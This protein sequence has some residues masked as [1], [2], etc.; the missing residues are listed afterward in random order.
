MTRQGKSAHLLAYDHGYS[1]SGMISESIFKKTLHN[2]SNVMKTHFESLLNSSPLILFTDNLRCHCTLGVL[3]LAEKLLQ[4]H[5]DMFAPNSSHFLAP[6]DNK[7]F[8]IFKSELEMRY[9]ELLEASSMIGKK[10]KAPLC[11]VVAESFNKAFAPPVV[12]ESYANVGVWPFRPDII[13]E[14]ARKKT[15]HKNLKKVKASDSLK[16]EVVKATVTLHENAVKKLQKSASAFE[17]IPVLTPS[18]RTPRQHTAVANFEE[19]KGRFEDLLA[20]ERRRAQEKGSQQKVQVNRR[21]VSVESEVERSSENRVVAVDTEQQKEREEENEEQ[22]S[23]MNRDIYC[24]MP[25]C[26]ETLLKGTFTCHGW[27]I[28]HCGQFS[29]CQ[30]HEKSLSGHQAI[31]FHVRVCTVREKKMLRQ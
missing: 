24:S 29:C 2:F 12:R 13:M 25:G 16:N 7:M 5:L 18:R 8:A 9:D 26:R 11:A 19:T 1:E 4:I 22:R 21:R 30:T 14:N 28:C 6:L 31:V 10:H 27:Y 17:N 20:L 23:G 3:E 15:I